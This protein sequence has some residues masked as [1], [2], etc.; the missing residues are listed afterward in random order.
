MR[1]LL[2]IFVA[3]TVG[4]VPAIADH[5]AVAA[6]TPAETAAREIADARERA[7]AAAAAY[8]EAQAEIERL[9]TDNAALAVDVDNLRAEVADLDAAAQAFAIN[10]FV[11]AGS[12]ASPLLLSFQQITDQMQTEVL[13]EVVQSSSADD[14]EL[15]ETRSEELAAAQQQLDDALA[16]EEATRQRMATLRDT[17]TEEVARLQAVEAQ[18]LQDEAVRRALEIEQA[19]R[20]QEQ[21]AAAAA[22]DAEQRAAAAAAA[23]P[24]AAPAPAVTDVVIGATPSTAP[25]P[26]AASPA[27]PPAAGTTPPTVEPAPETDEPEPEPE[28]Q[29]GRGGW[30]CPTGYAAVSFSDTYGASRSGGRSHE[31]VD[32][33]GGR[34]TPLLAVVDGSA[35]GKQTSL[36]GNSVW[37]TGND[38]NKYF[39][40]HL[41]SFG[42]SG[43]VQAG[44]VIGYM[45]DT[46]NARGS[47]VHLHFEIHPGGGSSINPYP[48]VRAH[49]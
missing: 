18:R 1:R 44:D 25:A 46:G 20:A 15:L 33:I 16:E 26:A 13:A 29:T 5:R 41:D 43:A 2:L 35:F 45:G 38:G 37:L 17:A 6:E 14:A 19:R 47:V 4:L 30:V 36:G 22:R 11:N 12:V 31:G 27:A 34:G 49:C 40:A 8:W 32:M 21:A 7:D 42:Q 3:A 28:P 39:Y 24:I 48:T 23:P 9:E 10:R